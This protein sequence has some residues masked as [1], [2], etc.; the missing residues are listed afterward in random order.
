MPESPLADLRS[1]LLDSAIAIV[2][3]QGT[4]GLTVRAVA[5]AAGCSTMGVYT[6]FSG[7]S[8]LIDA[9]VEAGFDS[10]DAA[11][12]RAFEDGG[13][14]HDG[15]IATGLAYR[16][17]ALEHAP[18]F[19]TMFVPAVAGHQPSDTTRDRT[20]DSFFAHRARVAAALDS[21]DSDPTAWHEAA[22]RMWA[23]L[24]GHVSLE[25]LRR[26]HAMSDEPFSDYAAAVDVA[27]A[28][29]ARGVA[30]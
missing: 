8:G 18:Q 20:W 12:D 11:L 19:H 1:R 24:H 7:K 6:H 9:V 16:T 22:A 23:T 29:D 28:V 30:N 4:A 2:E 14:G 17:W 25:L 5:K 27:L 21:A 10:L 3:A 15:L 26:T 13:G